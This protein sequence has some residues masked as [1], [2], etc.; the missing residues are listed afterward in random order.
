MK[1]VCHRNGDAGDGSLEDA[2]N[3]R[4]VDEGHEGKGQGDKGHG[5]DVG[6][7]GEEGDDGEVAGI[8]F[9]T[10]KFYYTLQYVVGKTE[11]HTHT[12]QCE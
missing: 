10:F 4:G 5:G 6:R 2:Q 11:K 12:S 7:V 8:H 9:V 3:S 1:S